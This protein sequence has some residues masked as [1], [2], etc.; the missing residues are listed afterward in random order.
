MHIL[1]CIQ[2]QIFGVVFKDKFSNIK[3]AFKNASKEI[4]NRTRAS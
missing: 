1:T 3:V 4:A 2:P